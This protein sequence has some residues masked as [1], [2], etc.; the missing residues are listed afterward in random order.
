MVYTGDLKDV[1]ANSSLSTGDAECLEF[2]KN[3]ENEFLRM[4]KD[5]I[6]KHRAS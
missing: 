1:I 4:I 2:Y 6:V 5:K 3:E